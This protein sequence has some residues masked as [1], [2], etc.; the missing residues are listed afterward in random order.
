[1]FSLLKKIVNNYGEPIPTGYVYLV[2]HGRLIVPVVWLEKFR[3]RISKKNAP[4]LIKQLFDSFLNP[5]DYGIKGGSSA[6]QNTR[7][8]PVFDAIQCKL[9]L[10][11]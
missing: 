9:F 4:R 3:A 10:I 11:L 8:E 1:M 5:Q 7:I 6:L 2:E